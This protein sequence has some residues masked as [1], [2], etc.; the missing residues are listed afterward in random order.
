[1]I[2]TNHWSASKRQGILKFAFLLRKVQ[3][4]T[5]AQ[6][7]FLLPFPFLV[8]KSTF[9]RVPFF[10]INHFFGIVFV[11][12]FHQILNFFFAKIKCGL[13]FLDR[14]DV[15]IS[16]MIFKKWKKTLLTCISAQ[17]AIWKTP[18]TTLPNTLKIEVTWPAFINHE[19]DYIKKKVYKKKETSW[20]D[21]CYS[22]NSN[23]SRIWLMWNFLWYSLL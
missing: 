22:P 1:M 6:Q 8:I 3:K 4:G 10:Q 12:A 21:P 11:T 13:Y 19:I 20:N 2:T 14:F 18:A 23:R 7:P 5:K 16:K 9:S 15:L 17:K